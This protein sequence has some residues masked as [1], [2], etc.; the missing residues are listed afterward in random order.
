MAWEGSELSIG[1]PRTR[2]EGVKGPGEMMAWEGSE[3]CI[4]PP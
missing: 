2:R 3:L 1:P 4:G